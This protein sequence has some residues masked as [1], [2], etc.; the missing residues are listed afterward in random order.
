MSEVLDTPVESP[1]D[2]PVAGP[3]VYAR[4]ARYN[5]QGQILAFLTVP[6]GMPL[7]FVE[8]VQVDDS[9]TARSHY[10]YPPTQEVIAFTPAEE[11]VYSSTPTYP[12]VWNLGEKRWDDLRSLDQLK[13]D[14]WT[15]IKLA[16]QGE[17]FS[18]FTHAGNTFD[19]DAASV[20]RLMGAIQL[21]QMA[22][23]MGGPFAIDW[24]LADNTVVNLSALDLI[25]A[26]Q[27]LG[28]HVNSAHAKARVLREQIAAAPDA[29]TVRAISW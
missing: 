1:V 4:Y 12:A 23:S 25:Q 2:A 26:G 13:A 28:V 21:A 9:V 15:E 27:A 20:S 19:C 17:E 11:A 3:P 14:K 22:L 7:P 6:E 29:G 16:R 8:M 18:T 10:V 24:T 5:P